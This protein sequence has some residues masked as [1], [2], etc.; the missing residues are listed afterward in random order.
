MKILKI[1]L[2][3]IL[4]ISC[5]GNKQ[6]V[7]TSVQSQLL[8]G[9]WIPYPIPKWL[10]PEEGMPPEIA[11]QYKIA[12]HLTLYFKEDGILY[13]FGSSNNYSGDSI[14]FSY[15]PKIS[16]FKGKW[17][18]NKNVIYTELKEE[19]I[20]GEFDYEGNGKPIYDTLNYSISKDTLINFRGITYKKTNR[21]D[22]KSYKLFNAYIY[23]NW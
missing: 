8:D 7:D 20:E 5:N 18:E 10:P 2:I 3:F 16:F 19:P 22:Y 13:L 1:L 6:K 17:T 4:F 9:V 21:F 11:N 23:N 14:I 12:N 15:E